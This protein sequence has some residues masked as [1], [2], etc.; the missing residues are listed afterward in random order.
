M[1]ALRM[2]SGRP[3]AY[4]YVDVVENHLCA[5]Y[6]CAVGGTIGKYMIEAAGKYIFAVVT[7]WAGSVVLRH[8]TEHPFTGGGGVG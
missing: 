4:A 8:D 1:T 3:G 5:G 6:H 2:N 7:N